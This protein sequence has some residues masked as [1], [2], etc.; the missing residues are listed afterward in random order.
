MSRIEFLEPGRITASRERSILSG[1]PESKP[2]RSTSG[3]DSKGS[4]SVKLEIP[5]NRITPTDSAPRPPRPQ[6]RPRESSPAMDAP[7]TQ[8][9]TPMTRTPVRASSHSTAGAKR[10]G[11]PR[12]LLKIT[13]LTRF[14]SAP[15]SS[16]VPTTEARDPPRSTSV[17][18]RTGTS[19]SRATRMFTI[20]VSF[21]FTSAGLPAPSITTASNCPA[22]CCSARRTAKRPWVIVKVR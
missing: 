5:G 9:I 2:T 4:R 12:N 14:R 20:S 1:V 13:P 15:S 3:S 16:S 19:A 21:R 10:A 17:T 18:S 8:G 7:S 22:M 11:S 6:R